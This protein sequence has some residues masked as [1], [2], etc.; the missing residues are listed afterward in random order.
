MCRH[1]NLNEGKERKKFRYE[2]MWETHDGFCPMLTDSWTKGGKVSTLV[3]LQA[4]LAAVS[5]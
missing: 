3:E 2:L 5:V 1:P 4:K